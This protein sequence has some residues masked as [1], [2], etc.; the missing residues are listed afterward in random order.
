MVAEA[1]TQ[2]AQEPECATWV[3]EGTPKRALSIIALAPTWTPQVKLRQALSSKGKV[4][5]M[6]MPNSSLHVQSN[7]SSSKYC[8]ARTWRRWSTRT[9]AKYSRQASSI[10]SASL[11]AT[12]GSRKAKNS[13]LSIITG[14]RAPQAQKWLTLTTSMV[15]SQRLARWC[16]KATIRSF[17]KWLT[18]LR[19]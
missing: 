6:W 9:C 5:K 8:R 16:A 3:T 2:I 1:T 15:G 13:L 10:S 11:T 17:Q 4:H 12:W 14:R 18:S 7:R 19:R